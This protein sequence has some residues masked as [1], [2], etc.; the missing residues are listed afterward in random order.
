MLYLSSTSTG[1]QCSLSEY[2]SLVYYSTIDTLVKEINQRFSELNLSLLQALLPTSDKFLDV[3]TLHPFL[4]HYEIDEDEVRAE[5]PIAMKFL[6]EKT[7]TNSFVFLHEVYQHLYEVKECFPKLLECLQIAMTMC[8]TTASAERSFS[9]LRRLKTYLRSTMTQE[10]LCNLPLLHIERD[11]S[12][13]LW[14]ILDE[15][16]LKFSQTRTNSR[17]LLH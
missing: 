6:R 7:G 4:Q 2:R 5:A 14:D 12:S 10:R 15:L 17:L 13:K 9:S 11:L 16:V 3:N 8:L 1:A